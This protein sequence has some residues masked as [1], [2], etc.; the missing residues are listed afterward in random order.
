[1]CSH[2][3]EP[4]YTLQLTPDFPLSITP[5]AYRIDFNADRA[6]GHL[7]AAWKVPGYVLLF[8]LQITHYDIAYSSVSS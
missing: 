5:G 4:D 1:M 7:K 2:G 3:S 6:E 8:S